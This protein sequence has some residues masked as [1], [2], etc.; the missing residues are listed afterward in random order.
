MAWLLILALVIVL[1]FAKGPWRWLRC[2]DNAALVVSAVPRDTSALVPSLHTSL[3]TR[4]VVC[5][6]H[7]VVA[8][9]HL[10]LRSMEVSAWCDAC[11]RG[12]AGEACGAGGGEAQ[13]FRAVADVCIGSTESELA[14]AAVRLLEMPRGDIGHLAE[15]L[16][17]MALADAVAV[18]VPAGPSPFVDLPSP[19]LRYASEDANRCGIVAVTE[20]LR[21]EV[22]DRY[23]LSLAKLGMRVTQLD[24]R[25]SRSPSRARVVYGGGV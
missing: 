3:V 21:A 6:N 4:G 13:V 16:L 18:G 10:D 22:L 24:I 12:G 17:R 11:V 25:L 19:R 8:V 5:F 9:R 7:R 15:G 23:S 20:E 2:P 14:N 1:L